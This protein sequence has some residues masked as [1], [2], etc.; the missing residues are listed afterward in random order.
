[1]V[2]SHFIITS[3]SPQLRVTGSKFTRS[4]NVHFNPPWRHWSIII[5]SFGTRF[6]QQCVAS[7]TVTVSEMTLSSEVNDFIT[8]Q[9]LSKAQA[10]TEVTHKSCCGGVVATAMVSP[11]AHSIVLLAK[12][13]P[14]LTSQPVA[15]GGVAE[16]ANEVNGGLWLATVLELSVYIYLLPLTPYMP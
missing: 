2:Q 7:E 6:Q 10:C 16:Y 9:N 4:N 14:L 13:L 1:M 8:A 15:V 3:H 11:P 5:S 12:L